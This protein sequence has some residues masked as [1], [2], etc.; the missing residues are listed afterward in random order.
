LEGDTFLE[1][2]SAAVKPT[3][4]SNGRNIY[5]FRFP[6]LAYLLADVEAEVPASF[7]TTSSLS[8]PRFPEDSTLLPG[9]LEITLQDGIVVHSFPIPEGFLISFCTF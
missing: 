8:V 6:G 7:L 1:P 5:L 9:P 2:N 4:F 3:G